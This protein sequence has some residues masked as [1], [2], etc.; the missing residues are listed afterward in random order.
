MIR[1][2]QTG[3]YSGFHPVDSVLPD[4]PKYQIRVNDTA[5]VFFYCSAPNSC[6]KYG[7]VGAINPNSSASLSH[8]RDIARKSSYSLSPGE[9]FPEEGDSPTAT[10]TP[11]APPTKEEHSKSLS[12]G[13]IA[14][15]VI[16]VIVG[17]VVLGCLAFFIGRSRTMKQEIARRDC[18]VK[19]TTPPSPSAM[20]QY[21][22]NPMFAHGYFQHTHEA[23][24]YDYGHYPPTSR[25]SVSSPP[26]LNRTISN[27]SVGGTFDLSSTTGYYT[28]TH[29]GE[30]T[31]KYCAPSSTD[32]E[33]PILGREHE[34]Y[35]HF[36]PTAEP[37]G[38]YE[39][40]FGDGH[41]GAGLY[42]GDGMYEKE[43]NWDQ[44]EAAVN[45]GRPAEMDGAGVD[46]RLQV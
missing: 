16:A 25:G 15:I 7:M 44:G 35:A 43:G 17:L 31:Y 23:P 32:A 40:H 34:S 28:R 11:P 26:R 6:I 46:G 37:V 39:S 4:P 8:Q 29:D 5:P 41:G 3:F 42:Y 9:P 24:A 12:P 20:L 36:G 10:P 22:P 33:S 18:T 30:D 27:R 38:S 45:E 19:C 13:A 2:N 14:G 1:P 21:T